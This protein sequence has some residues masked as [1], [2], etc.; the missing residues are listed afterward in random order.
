[1]LEEIVGESED[2][3]D[4]PK[5]Q[6]IQVQQDG[7][8]FVSGRVSLDELKDEVGIEIDSDQVETIGGY[9][10]H[11]AGKVPQKDEEFSDGVFRFNVMEADAKHVQWV[12]VTPVAQ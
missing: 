5:P 8:F 3:Y 9:V 1:V 2:E 4:P 6:E 7:S 12:A 10:C 11:L